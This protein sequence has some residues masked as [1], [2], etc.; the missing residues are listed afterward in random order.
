[1]PNSLVPI[2]DSPLSLSRTRLYFMDPIAL[3]KFGSEDAKKTGNRRHPKPIPIFNPNRTPLRTLPLAAVALLCLN[4]CTSA[5][6]PSGDG[7]TVEAVL[8]WLQLLP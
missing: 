1:M 6:G 4:P 7:Y 5:H 3:Q 8:E 2:R